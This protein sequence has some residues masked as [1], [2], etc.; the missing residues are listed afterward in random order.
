[1]LK[2]NCEENRDFGP[3]CD[4]FKAKGEGVA[5]DIQKPQQ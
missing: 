3:M 4:L 1:M 2:Q 5:G